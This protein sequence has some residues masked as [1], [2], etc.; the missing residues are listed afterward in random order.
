MGGIGIILWQ[1]LIVLPYS[2]AVQG[3]SLSNWLRDGATYILIGCAVIIALDAIGTTSV[4]TSRILVVLVGALAAYSFAARWIAARGLVSAQ[5]V[6]G[7]AASC[8]R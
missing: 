2:V 4:R 1:V 6:D 3:A 8:P 7:D 5:P